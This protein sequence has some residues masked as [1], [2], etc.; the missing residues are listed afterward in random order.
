MKEF[1]KYQFRNN[2]IC[3]V[4]CQIKA[5]SSREFQAVIVVNKKG[6][7]DFEVC[8]QKLN[9][10]DNIKSYIGDQAVYLIVEG[11][12]ILLKNIKPEADKP[13]IKQ[14]I[15]TAGENEF[16]IDTYPGVDKTYVALA[17]KELLDEI[18]QELERSGINVICL[19][20][21]PYRTVNLIKYF[22]NLADEIRFGN[23]YFH[24]SKPDH[25]I[26]VFEKTEEPFNGKLIIDSREVENSTLP[27]LSVAME[28]FVEE[29]SECYHEEIKQGKSEY[30]A[31][32]LFRKAGVALLVVVFLVLLV[33]TMFYLHYS[34]KKQYFENQLLGNRELKSKLD[35]LQKELE[36]KEK[37]M[38]GSGM[39]NRSKM[40]FYADRIAGTVT[41][42]IVLEKLEINPVT[43][44]IRSN[45]EIVLRPD[46]II[47]EGLAQSSSHLNNW[48]NRLK[49]LTWVNKVEILNYLQDA[50]ASSGFFSIEL[51]IDTSKS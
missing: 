18:T 9:T 51:G 5:D 28:Y 36:W 15:P 25:M 35:S 43:S 29:D 7:L 20:I 17:R 11:K 34:D 42:D 1:L 47:I 16:I 22:D 30:L 26:S 32:I 8:G 2:A 23:N 41:G 4:Y 49:E 12:G 3:G 14:I 33:N 27:A 21:G 40:A 39:M 48:I 19:A 46:I 45:K 13:L 24:F 44:K 31:R 6:M 37:F 10:P 50:D 38:Q